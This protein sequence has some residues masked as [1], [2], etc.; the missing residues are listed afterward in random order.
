MKVHTLLTVS[1]AG[2][3]AASLM[4]SCGSANLE[5][6]SGLESNDLQT[7]A[8]Q[9]SAQGNGVTQGNYA[10]ASKFT[11]QGRFGRGVQSGPGTF[12]DQAGFGLALDLSEEQQTEMQALREAEEEF[13]TAQRE[14]VDHEAIQNAIK[15]AFLADDFDQDALEAQIE[16]LRPDR[17]AAQLFHAEMMLK[18]WNILTEEQQATLQ[19]QQAKRQAM[20]EAR[21]TEQQENALQNRPE[22][23]RPLN[24]LSQILDLS[25]E[26]SEALQA[27]LEAQRPDPATRQTERQAMHEALQA[28]LTSD[29]PSVDQLVAILGEHQPERG[30]HLEHLATL[31]DILTSEQREILVEEGLLMHGPMNGAMNGPMNGSMSGPMKGQRGQ[32]MNGHKGHGPGHGPGFGPGFGPEA[33]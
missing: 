29:S 28:E 20:R 21:Q 22:G 2:L 10:A 17:E 7:L 13:R 25:D 1:L 24:R 27:A 3:F 11:R 5:L 26:Q 30:P 32:G 8:L 12:C 19:E 18:R 33:F 6:A 15:T 4:S 9:G 23:A 16:A 31:H 14:A